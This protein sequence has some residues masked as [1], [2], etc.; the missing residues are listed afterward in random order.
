MDHISNLY[1]NEVWKDII[2][3]ESEYQIS[4]LGRVKSLA[5]FGK[6]KFDKILKQTVGKRG[7]FEV[8]LYKNMS[9]KCKTIHRL[10]AEHF[11][12]NPENKR[13]VNHIDANKLNNNISNLEWVTPKE[14]SIHAARSPNVNR[15]PRKRGVS[16]SKYKDK[17]YWVSEIRFNRKSIYLGTFK[18]KEEAYDKYYNKYFELYGFYPWYWELVD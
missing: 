17:I 7:Y 12:V 9:F 4:S 2:G 10:V 5:R 14:N 15:E 1:Q 18:D 8:Q 6:R 11:I 13:E 16:K 3:Y